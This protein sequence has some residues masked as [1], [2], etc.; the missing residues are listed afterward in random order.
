MP[1]WVTLESAWRTQARKLCVLPLI[2]QMN[3]VFVK[4]MM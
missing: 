1:L 3:D 2:V 4:I